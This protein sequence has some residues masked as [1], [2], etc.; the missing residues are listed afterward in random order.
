LAFSGGNLECKGASGA[1]G[2]VLEDGGRFDL[3]LP[4]GFPFTE[5]LSRPT[6][7]SP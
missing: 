6:G 4:F 3:S 2:A 7:F 1:V 5:V